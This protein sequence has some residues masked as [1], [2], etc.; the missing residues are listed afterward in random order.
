MDSNTDAGAVL[1]AEERTATLAALKL[2]TAKSNDREALRSVIVGE[3][4]AMVTD[5]YLA[6][7]IPALAGLPDG[8][9]CAEALTAAIKGYRRSE[10]AAIMPDADGLAVRRIDASPHAERSIRAEVAD[11][12][13]PEG[14]VAAT[15]HVRRLGAEVV[16]PRVAGI[17]Q[18]A[19]SAIE[20]PAY[21]PEHAELAGHRLAAIIKAAPPVGGDRRT[22]RVGIYPRG[23]R[24]AV[25]TSEERPYAVLMPMR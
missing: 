24:P 15:Y 19:V 22:E 14:L 16:V 1:G 21:T 17:Y 4:L 12:R 25:I 6:V 2:A 20:D 3:G 8:A 18:D 9:Y 10:L 7:N 23:L 5:T 11:G 13:V